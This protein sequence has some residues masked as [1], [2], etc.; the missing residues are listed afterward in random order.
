MRRFTAKSSESSTQPAEMT[1]LDPKQVPDPVSPQLSKKEI[2]QL[3]ELEFSPVAA[4]ELAA[5][6]KELR[7][8]PNEDLVE[9]E[10]S[11]ARTAQAIVK[12]DIEEK[13]LELEKLPQKE[14]EIEFGKKREKW[15]PH[16]EANPLL[17][18]FENLLTHRGQ[19]MVAPWVVRA[20]VVACGLLLLTAIASVTWLGFRGWKKVQNSFSTARTAQ[21][22]KTSAESQV[23]LAE[24]AKVAQ[25]QARSFFQTKDIEQKKQLIWHGQAQRDLIEKHYQNEGSLETIPP[26]FAQAKFLPCGAKSLFMVPPQASTNDPRPA[27]FVETDDGFR[28]DWTSYIVPQTTAWDEWIKNGSPHAVAYRVRLLSAKIGSSRPE[29]PV[30]QADN[31]EMIDCEIASVDGG[32]PIIVKVPVVARIAA[33]VMQKASLEPRPI[34]TVMLRRRSNEATARLLDIHPDKWAKVFSPSQP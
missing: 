29:T 6:Q 4:D 20:S 10:V 30:P 25:G 8:L 19:Q 1:P 15:R 2:H 11:P 31:E 13:L 22:A 17:S 5:R 12:E 16:F 7:F 34:I 9:I 27:V 26:D 18:L 14:S 23:S 21:T 3:E 28:L 33:E 32:A 24:R